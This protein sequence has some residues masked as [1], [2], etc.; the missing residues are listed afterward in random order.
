M[1][2]VCRVGD[3]NEA[4]G[5]ILNGDPSV[6]INGRAIAVTDS[7][8]TPHPCCG[9]RGCPPTHCFAR[10]KAKKSSVLVNGKPVVSIGDRDTCGHVR[11]GGSPDVKI[12]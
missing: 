4:G 5:I 9:R 3:R 10:T 2:S 6:L 12:G 7:R 11:L 1:A 8:V